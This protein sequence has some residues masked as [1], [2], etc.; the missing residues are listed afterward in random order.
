MRC[1]LC[2]LAL[3]EL[4]ALLLSQ[5]VTG[6]RPRCNATSSEHV[7]HTLHCTLHTL[8]C[9]LHTLHFTLHTCTS[10]STAHLIS[11]HLISSHHMSPHLT[12]S[13]LIPSLLTYHP[14]KFFSTVFIS[15]K[16][17]KKVHLNSFQ[18]FCTP[19]SSYCKKK[20]FRTKSIERSML[21]RTEA[22]HTDAFRQKKSWQHTLYCT[23]CTKNFPI[24]SAAWLYR[25]FFNWLVR[26]TLDA[27]IGAVGLTA[28]VKVWV[29]CDVG[30]LLSQTPFGV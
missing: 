8:H 10:H 11:N 21:L 24:W 20:A 28:V 27:G 29:G 13:H 1:A 25:E 18:L 14:S 22:W 7:L 26:C 6:V 12:S 3:R 23:A 19:E 5:N 9:T 16:H 15:S 4:V 2:V 17:W 30:K